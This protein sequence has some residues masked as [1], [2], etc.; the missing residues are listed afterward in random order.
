[1]EGSKT[2]VR[3]GR[4]KRDSDDEVE[5]VSLLPP[6]SNGSNLPDIGSLNISGPDYDSSPSPSAN[7]AVV[8][9]PYQVTEIIDLS[10]DEE[11]SDTDSDVI[12]L[13]A[14]QIRGTRI[15]SS[16]NDIVRSR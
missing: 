7:D 14:R 12:F 4:R 6:P 11:E 8:V 9:L 15:T 3:L 1:M 10:D 5:I 16:R 13:S 2:H